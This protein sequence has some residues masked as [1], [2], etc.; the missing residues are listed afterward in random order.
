[1]S[2]RRTESASGSHKSSKNDDFD[3]DKIDDDDLVQ[4][5]FGDLAFDHIENFANP[6]DA[7]TQKNTA[8]NASKKTAAK[9]KERSKSLDED[10]YEPQQLPNGKW[11]CNH[12]CKDKSACKHMCCR[13]GVDKPPKKPAKRSAPA[14]E[15]G[16]KATSKKDQTNGRKTQTKLQLTASKR[17]SSADIEM[18]DLTQQEKKRKTEYAKSGPK[19]FRNLHQLHRTIQKKDPP[20]SIS[21][22]MHKKPPYCYAAGGEHNLSFLDNDARIEELGSSSSDYGDLHIEEMYSYPEEPT[23]IRGE[24][25]TGH[26][27][28]K[29]N[30][31]L[32]DAPVDDSLPRSH[33][34]H[35]DA[36]DDDDD[37]LL[38]EAMI[39]LADSQDM[40][41]APRDADL[42][43]FESTMNLDDED[44][45][46]GDGDTTFIL[47]TPPPSKP[48]QKNKVLKHKEPEECSPFFPKNVSQTE[49]VHDGLD[50]LQPIKQTRAAN[51][52][53][54][55]SMKHAD[56]TESTA[57]EKSLKHISHDQED[58]EPRAEEK[59]VPDGFKDLEPWLFA[60]FGDIIEL[61]DE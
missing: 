27:Q 13:D 29:A 25:E 6:T 37:S 30:S 5:S 1:M 55:T 43:A 2:R 21:S 8:K 40:Q 24:D 11:A 23:R 12:K 59:S 7:L 31:G 51:R 46:F 42:R 57:H 16:S 35:T 14:E 18:L 19:D 47:Q 39:G 45:E 36:F 44:E 61:V 58:I 4:A 26:R 52:P 53:A 34:D 22:V 50:V 60:E 48:A 15:A 10:E 20:S 33:K 49:S 9:A 56:R 32:R 3:D 17:R 54:M 28:Q 38:R 41:V